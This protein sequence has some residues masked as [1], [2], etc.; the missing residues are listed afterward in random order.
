MARC[1]I[2]LLIAPAALWGQYQAGPAGPPPES[3]PAGM[4]KLFDR[5]GF[6]VTNGSVA[7]CEIWFRRDRPLGSRSPAQNLTLPSIPFGA[8]LGVIRFDGPGTDRR[9][10]VIQPGLYTLRYGIMPANDDHQGAAPQRDFLLL[11]PAGE[12]N[13][14][15][16]TPNFDTLVMMS[17]KASG[18]R[19]PAVLSIWKTDTDAPGFSRQGEDWVLQTKLA[20]T[21][22]AIILIGTAGA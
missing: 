11:S 16:S 12:D 14:P 1:L 22:I 8:L 17:R 4:A 13:D 5:S 15:D 3:L 7:Y 2:A 20:D 19:H 6:K 10:Q 21:P 9:G 18:S